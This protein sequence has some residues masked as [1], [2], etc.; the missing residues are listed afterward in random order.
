LGVLKEEIREDTFA[1]AIWFAFA[2]AL[3]F[4]IWDSNT[5][6]RAKKGKE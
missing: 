3:V 5:V 2:F 1:F 4:A 6:N